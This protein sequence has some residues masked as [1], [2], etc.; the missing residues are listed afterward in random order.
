MITFKFDIDKMIQI[1]D[2][3]LKKF[4]GKVNY[5][6]LIK[7][8]YIADKEA[9]RAYGFII[10]NDKHYS[11]PKGPILSN[12]YSLIQDTIRGDIKEDQ[13]FYWK[14][15][16]QKDGYEIK[17][18]NTNNL[19]YTKL[20]KADKKILDKIYEEHKDKTF[21]ELIELTHNKE[22][23]PE[24]KWEQAEAAVTPEGKNIPIAIE[25]ILKA[26][27]V[28]DNEIELIAAENLAQNKNA[29]F[30]SLNLM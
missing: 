29:E 8:L 12:L 26:V 18:V 20:C 16:F 13:L 22:L 28:P 17:H 1:T 2:Y 25:E 7:M 19:S 21:T 27:G 9:L 15:F 5:T 11:L 10:S 3:L 6:K 24:V 4:G 14:T 30:I 23:F